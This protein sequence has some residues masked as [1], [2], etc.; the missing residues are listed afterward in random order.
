[1]INVIL[2]SGLSSSVFPSTHVVFPILD[3]LG[4]FHL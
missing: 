4:Q 3:L 1:L 2:Y